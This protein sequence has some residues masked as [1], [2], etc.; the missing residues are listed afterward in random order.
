MPKAYRQVEPERA[1]QF[2]ERRG[3]NGGGLAT[4]AH[5]PK[6]QASARASAG[7]SKGRIRSPR[8]RASTDI[9]ASAPA[10][11]SWLAGALIGDYIRAMC[12]RVIQSSGPLRYAIVDGM[13]VR[14]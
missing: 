1:V 13:N 9:A 14:D 8:I 12:G 7:E 2:V 4:L 3:P 6:H 10:A 5:R 11:S